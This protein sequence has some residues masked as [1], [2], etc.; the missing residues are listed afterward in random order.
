LGRS[1]QIDVALQ[2]FVGVFTEDLQYVDDWRAVF[3]KTF[4]S[5]S[6]FWFDSFTS[7]PWAFLDLQLYMVR[8]NPCRVP[9]FSFH[10]S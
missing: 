2:F 1:L 5:V 3:F 7:I 6:G 4:T 10:W 8:K 9:F